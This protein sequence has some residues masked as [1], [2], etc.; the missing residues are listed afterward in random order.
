MKKERLRRWVCRR[1]DT[2]GSRLDVRSP[3]PGTARLLPGR[4]EVK[5]FSGLGW[6]FDKPEGE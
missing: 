2:L 4:E 6:S 1:D 5:M 3:K